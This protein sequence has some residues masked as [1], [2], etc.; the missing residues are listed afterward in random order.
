MPVNRWLDDKAFRQ[1]TDEMVESGWRDAATPTATSAI[2]A[3]QPANQTDVH[4]CMRDMV[5]EI[6]PRRNSR[7][8][9]SAWLLGFDGFLK[10]T[11]RQQINTPVNARIAGTS[12]KSVQTASANQPNLPKCNR[13]SQERPS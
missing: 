8:H 1:L 7:D 2:S 12:P 13:E 5:V 10:I 11:R 6:V 3:T 4:Q 9:Q